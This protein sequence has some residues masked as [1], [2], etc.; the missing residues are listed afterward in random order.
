MVNGSGRARLEASGT[1]REMVGTKPKSGRNPVRSALER[2]C[3]VS[4]IPATFGSD[5][6]VALA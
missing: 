3:S 2:C 6:T 5:V 1:K 4:A